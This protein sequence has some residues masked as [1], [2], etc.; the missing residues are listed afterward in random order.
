MK[1]AIVTGAGSG[2]GRAIAWA[3][4]KEG[5]ALAL[6]GRT[7]K[8]LTDVA[9]E[10]TKAGGT[11]MARQVDVRSAEMI[12]KFYDDVMEVYGRVDVL[13]NNAGYA[14]DPDPIHDLSPWDLQESLETN[15]LGPFMFMHRFLPVMRRQYRE[16]A[17]RSVI[18]NIASKAARWPTP[19]MSAYSASKAALV[20]ITQACAK[21]LAED[22]VGVKVISI[23]PGGMNTPMRVEVAGPENAALQQSPESVAKIVADIVEGR[24]LVDSSRTHYDYIPNGADVLVW[25]EKVTVYPVEDRR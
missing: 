7:W 9:S 8:K 21:E 12:G 23:S 19:R 2:L 4:H 25:K 16:H 14:H 11:T 20:A 1:V 3:L 15:V 18:V 13:V 22:E 24:P 6:C 10:I 17:E 5:Y